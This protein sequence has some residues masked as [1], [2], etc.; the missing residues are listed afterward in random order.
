[1]WNTAPRPAPV[2]EAK[3]LPRRPREYA[4]SAERLQ[5]LGLE[6][7]GRDVVPGVSH[8]RGEA[9]RLWVI[10]T[11]GEAGKGLVRMG[12]S[13]HA[14]VHFKRERLPAVVFPAGDEKIDREPADYPR[15][16]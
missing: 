10:T 15:I 3:V 12:R 6:M 8:T 5:L 7:I 9:R 1:M 14:Q 16:R 13:A 2:V 4:F 11:A